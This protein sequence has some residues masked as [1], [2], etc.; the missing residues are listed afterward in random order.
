MRRA[1]RTSTPATCVRCAR[2]TPEPRRGMC[3]RCYQAE[4]NGRQT[5]T[6]C[7][8]C[9]QADPRVLVRKRLDGLHWHTLCGN[10]SVLAGKRTLTVGALQLELHPEGDRRQADR[11]LG[12]DRRRSERRGV[13]DRRTLDRSTPERRQGDRR[14]A[15]PASERRRRA[16]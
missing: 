14:D 11:R 16:A 2:P 4:H 6:A 8:C 5:A 3:Q 10:C 13:L 9:S 15:A 1:V 12:A 7:E